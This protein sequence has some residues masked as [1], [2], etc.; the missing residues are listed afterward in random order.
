VASPAWCRHRL[1]ASP[2]PASRNPGT[3]AR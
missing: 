1:R 2:L 3:D